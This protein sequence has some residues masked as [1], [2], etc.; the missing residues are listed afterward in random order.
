MKFLKEVPHY[1]FKKIFPK[2]IYNIINDTNRKLMLMQIF[3]IYAHYKYDKYLIKKVY[4]NRWKKNI[5]IFNVSDIETIHI[6]N[7][8][9]HC[10]SVEKIIIKEIKCG[11]H[12]DSMNFI[13]CLCFRVRICLKRILL[14]HYLLKIIDKKKYYLFK[15]YKK[16]FGKIRPIYL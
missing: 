1:T 10:F 9:D 16:A 8:S 6:K 11:I 7:I 3:Y 15:W 14:R 5:K 13:D 4:W 2:K 12:P